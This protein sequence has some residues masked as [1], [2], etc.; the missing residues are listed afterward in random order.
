MSTIPAPLRQAVAD[1]EVARASRSGFENNPDREVARASRSGNENNPDRDGL[2]TGLDPASLAITSGENLPHWTS[3]NVIYHV[4]FRLADSVPRSKREA[5]IRERE[6]IAET[7]LRADRKLTAEEEERIRFLYSERIEQFLDSGHGECLLRQ[8]VIADLVA[9]ALRY[10]EGQRYILHSWCVMPNHVH[11]IV[12]PLP[13]Y[14]LSKIIHSWK[15][16]TAHEI[17]HRLGRTGDVW[18][19]DAY[20][21]IIRSAKEYSFQ[22]AYVW[23]NPDKAQLSS[24]HW[25]WVITRASRSGSENRK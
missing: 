19:H 25:R 15:S 10:F 5:W 12:Q 16:F 21:H 7:A 9:G 6:S 3:D 8:P 2:A 18:Q 14:D 24:W 13:G 4:V 17:N 20:N 1:R 22:I 23:E 11:V